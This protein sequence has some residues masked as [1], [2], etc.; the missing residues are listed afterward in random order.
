ML[1]CSCSTRDL[2]SLL[3]H[4][5]SLIVACK[6]LVMAC[7]IY[8]LDQGPAALGAH[9]LSHWTTREV[10]SLSSWFLFAPTATTLTQ[11]VIIS[12][13]DQCNSFLTGCLA[14]FSSASSHLLIYRSD[15]H[16]LQSKTLQCL[17]IV[18]KLLQFSSV[19]QSC[20]TLWDP[21]DC[22]M[23]GFPVHHQFP[24]LTQIHVHWIGD[25]I[26]PSHPLS[27]LLLLP[28]IFPRIRVFSNESVLRIRWPKYWSSSFSISP[29]NEYSGLI[30]FRIDGFDLFAVQGTLKSLESPL[31]LKGTWKFLKGRKRTG[32]H[33]HYWVPFQ[34]HFLLAG[35]PFPHSPPLI[36]LAFLVFLECTEVSLQHWP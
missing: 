10:S 14:P 30:S 21:V 17:L 24:E 27:S 35:F 6:L 18:S 4:L 12:C 32:I 2:W 34:P 23:P 11:D 29:S 31:E 22:S 7:G 33:I 3:H 36:I 9:S 5:G 13:R 1:G 25:A 15:Q 8:F 16:S 28:S 20:L 19:A 26:Q